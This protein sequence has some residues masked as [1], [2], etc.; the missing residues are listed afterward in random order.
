[1]TEAKEKM[2]MVATHA[3]EDPERAIFPLLLANA[4]QAMDVDAVVVL[5][6]NGVYVAKKGYAAGVTFPGLTP[7]KTLVD[8]YVANGGTF[9]VCIPCLEERQISQADLIQGCELVKA[10]RLV[11]EMTSAKS[12]VVY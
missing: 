4:A 2:V 6:G 1:M 12:T 8:N 3:A 7:L 5:Q 10:G 11:V 9:L